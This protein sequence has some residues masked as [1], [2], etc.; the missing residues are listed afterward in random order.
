MMFIYA[1]NEKCG[2]T[3]NSCLNDPAKP[4][5]PTTAGVI[6]KLISGII[7]WIGI[8]IVGHFC[9][10]YRRR[11]AKKRF[12]RKIQAMVAQNQLQMVLHIISSPPVA[13]TP[14]IQEESPPS[15]QEIEETRQSK[16][17]L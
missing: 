8:C 9:R 1:A 11:Q 5:E 2:Y 7:F 17:Q 10:I 4:R 16:H 12:A 6:V 14:L 15:Y 13:T 3:Y